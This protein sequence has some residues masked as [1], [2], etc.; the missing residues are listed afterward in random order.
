MIADSQ[1]AADSILALTGTPHSRRRAKRAGESP[2]GF[3]DVRPKVSLREAL[4]DENLLGTALQGDS[5]RAWRALLIA[6]MGEPLLPEELEIFRALTGRSEAPQERVDECWIVAGRRGGKSKAMSTTALY[7]ATLCD[8]SDVLSPGERGVVTLIAPDQRQA[9]ILL[10]YA[11]GALT[12]SPLLSQLFRQR[13]Q[14]TLSLNNGIDLEVRSASFRRIR[15]VTNV[16]VL[17]D[18]AAFWLSEESANPDTEILNAI[19]PSLATTR[20]LLAVIGSPYARKG[21]V[22]NTYAKHFGQ[23]GDPKILVAHGASRDFNP[24]LPQEVIDRAM[25][26]DPAAASAEYLAQFRTDVELFLTIEAVRACVEAGVFE[27]PPLRQW[28][29]VAFVDPSGG[30]SDAMTLAIAHKEADTVIL[31]ALRET[32]PPFSPE[33]V[34]EDYATLLKKYRLTK[35]VGDRYAGEWVREPFARHG[36]NYE[37]AEKPKSDLYRDF[38]PLVNSGG[39]DL[40]DNARL[41]A[42]LVQLERRTA[43]GGRDSIDHPSGGH[44][45]LANA[46]AGAVTVAAKRSARPPG[47]VSIRH[48]SV[49]HYS[50]HRGAYSRGTIRGAYAR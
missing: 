21:E 37:I 18:E 25:E 39:V 28:R 15:G 30:S 13:V 41:I 26:R 14:D 33:S 46:A 36:I 5:W 20:G 2:N 40:L 45:D 42:Q 24:S 44:D 35:V 49:S 43:R 11:E 8:Y 9:R 1:S 50:P 29:Y 32:K 23:K 38:L 16:A 22:W 10:D 12:T 7:S 47:Q 31:D 17:A 6:M 19:R 48:E 4:T 27:R 3:C 34:V